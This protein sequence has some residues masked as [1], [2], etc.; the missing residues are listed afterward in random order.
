MEAFAYTSLS[1]YYSNCSYGKAQMHPNNSVVVTVPLACSGVSPQSSISWDAQSCSAQNLY[2]WM[3]QAEAYVAGVL[4]IDFTRFK[5]HVMVL[6]RNASGWGGPSC[7]W[8]GQGILGLMRGA[9]YSYAW[10][11]GDVWDQVRR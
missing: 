6:P 5:H 11:S 9:S 1:N 2:G 4:G 3:F 8:S 7:A 10:V